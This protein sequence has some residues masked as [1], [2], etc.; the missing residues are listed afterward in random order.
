M[1]IW[2]TYKSIRNGGNKNGRGGTE[3]L[4]ILNENGVGINIPRI[5]KH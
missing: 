1:M 2:Y 3:L 5:K 4:E